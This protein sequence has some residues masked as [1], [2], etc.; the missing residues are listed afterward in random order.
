MKE[1]DL[2]GAQKYSF[3]ATA[4]GSMFPFVRWNEQI[5]VK[6]VNTDTI[7]IGEIIL[8]SDK[9]NSKVAHRVVGVDKTNDKLIFQTKGDHNDNLDEPVTEDQ[10]IGKVVILKRKNMLFALPSEGFEHFRYKL[11][12]FSVS[13]QAFFRKIGGK[14]F[15]FFQSQSLYRKLLRMVLKERVKISVEDLSVKQGEKSYRFTASL[16]GY[17]IGSG[18]LAFGKHGWWIWSVGV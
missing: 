12:C 4:G 9:H 13:I 15:A 11:S 6:K 16:F 8:F 3:Y 18:Y 14:V 17:K 5:V 1:K 7:G 10:V 2:E